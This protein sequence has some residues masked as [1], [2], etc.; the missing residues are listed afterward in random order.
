MKPK[1]LE[2]WSVWLVPTLY[3]ASILS[4]TRQRFTKHYFTGDKRIASKIGA[5]I[6]QN[7]YGISSNTVTAGQKEAQRKISGDK[8]FLLLLHHGTV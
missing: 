2:G 5:D 6:F 7:A 4:V 3:L 8:L 1:G